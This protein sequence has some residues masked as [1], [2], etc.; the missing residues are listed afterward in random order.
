MN[1]L[2]GS[3][4]LKNNEYAAVGLGNF[5]GLHIGHMSLINTLISEAKINKLCSI[6]YTFVIHPENITRKKLVNY[7]LT[8]SE[9]KIEL[10][11]STNLD[12]LVFEDFNEEYSRMSPEDFIKKIL[13]K[14]LK[15]KLAVV[16][17]DYRFGYKGQ[18]DI[19]LLKEYGKKN[20]F[21][22]IVIPPIKLKDEIVSST[23]IRGLVKKGDMDGVFKYLGRHFSLTGDVIKGRN[24]GNKIGF[25]TANINIDQD[26]IIP[27]QGVYITKTVFNNEIFQSVTNIG[28]N[29]T[30]DGIEN[31][32]IET[33]I[34]DFDSHIYG[35]KIEVFF[36]KRLRSEKKFKTVNELIK[37]LKKD[38]NDARESF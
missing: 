11:K 6:V 8:N 20:D 24:V 27:K 34:L 5:D 29:P 31:L 21:K 32:C 7:L 25:P 17:F 4:N 35:K 22:V 33:H 12:N 14:K 23:L 18:G 3:N 15:I 38:V 36:L 16:G 37:Q 19:E 28:Y 9:K 10:L 2:F 30:F 26:Y 1:V 13:I